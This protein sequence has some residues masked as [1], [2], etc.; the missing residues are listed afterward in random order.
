MQECRDLSMLTQHINN[1]FVLI[2]KMHIYTQKFNI[3]QCKTQTHSYFKNLLAVI[4]VINFIK[5]QASK[6]I[7]K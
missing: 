3:T 1:T 4:A 7:N 2:I 6:L 5:K